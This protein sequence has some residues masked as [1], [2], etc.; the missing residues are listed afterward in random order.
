MPLD[1]EKVGGDT[2]DP[3]LDGQK[4]EKKWREKERKERGEKT[5]AS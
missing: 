5:P 3:Y 4:R 1:R 2:S